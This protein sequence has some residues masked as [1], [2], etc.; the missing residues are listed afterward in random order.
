MHYI[1]NIIFDRSSDDE[2]RRANALMRELIAKAAKEGYGE[3]RTHILYADQVSG[4][5]NWGNGALGRFNE[6]IKDALDPNG[7]LAPGRNGIWP[8]RY[9]GKGW[10]I[11]GTE[12]EKAVGGGTI[13]P[14]L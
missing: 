9:R 4:T 2:K 12:N 10:E 13:A 6:T 8:M 7:I 1:T 11:M 3:Y 14:K 5:Y